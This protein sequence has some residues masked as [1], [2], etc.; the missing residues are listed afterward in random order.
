MNTKEIFYINMDSAL[1]Q[2]GNQN[3]QKK[4]VVEGEN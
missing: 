4:I 1:K 3:E 2:S